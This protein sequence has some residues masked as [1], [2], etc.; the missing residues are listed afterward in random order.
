[1]RSAV[2]FTVMGFTAMVL[3]A[4]VAGIRL[5]APVDAQ[6]NYCIAPFHACR[7]NCL[8][9]QTGPARA[10]CMQACTRQLQACQAAQP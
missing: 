2:R 7:D 10:R 1:M 5:V 8:A 9:T 4:Q 3:T 6:Q